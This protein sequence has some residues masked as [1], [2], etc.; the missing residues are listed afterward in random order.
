MADIT[1]YAVF[2]SDARCFEKIATSELAV[3]TGG[4]AV[5]ATPEVTYSFVTGLSVFAR[6]IEVTE[7][8]ASEVASHHAGP[9]SGSTTGCPSSASDFASLL[10]SKCT[11]CSGVHIVQDG[12]RGRS[13]MRRGKPICV[14]RP[15]AV[16]AEAGVG[17]DLWCARVLK[18]VVGVVAGIETL[19]RDFNG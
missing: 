13:A 1:V 5:G 9:A 10:A 17:V 16:R 7:C 12:V 19:Q 18:D 11:C 15:V 14:D 3:D 2:V 4:V 8:A 6:F